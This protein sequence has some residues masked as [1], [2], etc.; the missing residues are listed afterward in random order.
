MYV[1]EDLKCTMK[2][3]DYISDVFLGSLGNCFVFKII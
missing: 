2:G 3:V 1:P